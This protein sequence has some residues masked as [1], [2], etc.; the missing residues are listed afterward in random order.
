[1]RNSKGRRGT[2]RLSNCNIDAMICLTEV[3]DIPSL[4]KSRMQEKG[5][6]S[7]KSSLPAFKA[8]LCKF[9]N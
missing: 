9:L 4:E 3:S 1:M 5:N 7:V 2:A 6:K 8:R